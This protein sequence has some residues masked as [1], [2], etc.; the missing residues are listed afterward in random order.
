MEIAEIKRLNL[1]DWKLFLKFLQLNLIKCNV[2]N[3]IFKDYITD[4]LITEAQNDY[5]IDDIKR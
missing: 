3:I 5:K 1:A 4:L 2:G